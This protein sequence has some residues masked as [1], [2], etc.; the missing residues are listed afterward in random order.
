T[1]GNS[2]PLRAVA[3]VTFATLLVLKNSHLISPVRYLACSQ[4]ASRLSPH[5]AARLQ[6]LPRLS[7]SAGGTDRSAHRSDL[8][9]WTGRGRHEYFSLR[10][11]ARRE[12]WKL[13]WPAGTACVEASTAP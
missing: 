6:P 1:P 11:S 10:I 9:L 8:D 3:D 7:E 12:A 5:F 4:D 2:T 13:T